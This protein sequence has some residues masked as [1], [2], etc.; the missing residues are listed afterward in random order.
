MPPFSNSADSLPRKVAAYILKVSGLL[1]ALIVA[2]ATAGCLDKS[3]FQIAAGGDSS[4]VISGGKVYAA[5]K[6][7][8]G[9]LGFGDNTDRDAFTEV[10]SLSGKNIVAI[11]ARGPYSLALDKEGKVYATGW[12]GYGQ[13]GLGDKTDRD[14]FTQISSLKDKKIVAISA[15]YDN[16]LALTSD[17]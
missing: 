13:L 17:G 1:L 6:N 4:F 2:L 14:K 12:N 10:L 3:G 9:Q 7:L 5:G 8:F 15:G 16:S 11:A